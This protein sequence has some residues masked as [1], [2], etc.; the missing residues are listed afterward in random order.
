MNETPCGKE[1]LDPANPLIFTAGTLVGS[2]KAL[3]EKGAVSVVA[4]FTHALL[5]GPALERLGLPEIGRVIVTDTIPLSE[6]ASRSDKITV[7][8]VAPMLAQAIWRIHRNESVSALFRRENG[9]G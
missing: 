9:A 2:A 8:S 6:E 7:L 1:P 5:S 4:C 3:L